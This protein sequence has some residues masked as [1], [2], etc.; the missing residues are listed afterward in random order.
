MA[1]NA[2]APGFGASVG[3]LQHELA[4]RGDALEIAGLMQ[5]GVITDVDATDGKGRTA[6]FLVSQTGTSGGLGGGLGGGVGSSMDGRSNY[7]ISG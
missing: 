5:R 7:F 4:R 6:L 2:A 3:M 1:T